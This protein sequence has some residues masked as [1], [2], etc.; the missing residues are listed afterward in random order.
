M[1]SLIAAVAA[2]IVLVF[3][4]AVAPADD[5]GEPTLLGRA[6]YSA[7]AYQPGPPSGAFIGAGDNGVVPP[8]PGQPI[9]GFSAVLDAGDGAVLGDAR[10]RLSARRENSSDFLLRLYRDQTA[11]SRRRR[12][13]SGPSRSS[14][15]IQ[16]RDPDGKV[17][18]PLTRSDRLLTGADFDLEVGA[19][20]RETASC[21][22]GRS[23]DRF[24]LHTDATGKV[25]E[26]PIALPGVQSPQNPFLPDP[27]AWTIRASR[28]FEA[29]ALSID[30]K[31]ALS[32]DRGRSYGTRSRSAAARA[33]R[34]QPPSAQRTRAGCGTTAS[35]RRSRTR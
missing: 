31:H 34:V 24:S 28:G 30:G 12:A 27:D 21:G 5:D 11:I 8:F 7:T 18:F 10:Q 16:L 1:K 17:P 13:E 4:T 22:S 33:K 26:A 2:A 32:D 23:S 15:F 20:D 6:I 14:G 19:A 25:L 35:M 9:P 3:F 29:M